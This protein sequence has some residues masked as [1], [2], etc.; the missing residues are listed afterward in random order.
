MLIN[1]FRHA[2]AQVVL[3]YLVAYFDV[4]SITSATMYKTI[5]SKK[6]KRSPNRQ[7]SPY[8]HPDHKPNAELPR[9]DICVI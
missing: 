8:R 6:L 7:K 1:A 5:F 9:D 4:T 3:A 2:H